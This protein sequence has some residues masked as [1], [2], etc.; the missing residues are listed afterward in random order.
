MPRFADVWRMVRFPP[1]LSNPAH[2]SVRGTVSSFARV[3]A[4]HGGVDAPRNCEIRNPR[5]AVRGGPAITAEFLATAIWAAFEC[6]VAAV[7]NPR[8]GAQSASGELG[9]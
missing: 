4:G 9:S 3:S 8:P 6:G 1:G 7:P 2:G 5:N